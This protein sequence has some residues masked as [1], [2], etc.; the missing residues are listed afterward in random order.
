MSNEVSRQILLAS[1]TTTFLATLVAT[2]L[3]MRLALPASASAVDTAPDGHD[4][5]LSAALAAGR[6]FCFAGR[7]H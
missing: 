1:V 4:G 3:V 7:Q 6:P 2:I 5:A